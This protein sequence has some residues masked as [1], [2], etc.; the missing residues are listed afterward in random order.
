MPVWLGTFDTPKEASLSYD[1]AARSLRGAKAHTNF[2]SASVSVDLCLDL[3]ALPPIAAGPLSCRKVLSSP[4]FFTPG[5][6]TSLR[7]SPRSPDTGTVTALS[8]FSTVILLPGQRR[9]RCLGPAVFGFLFLIFKSID[10]S[11]FNWLSLN[12]TC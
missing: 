5:S 3:N 10:M 12:P 9:W 1:G 8:P 6:S 11:L 4:S 2:K 7:L